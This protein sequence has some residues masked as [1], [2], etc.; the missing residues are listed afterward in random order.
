[1]QKIRAVLLDDELAGLKTLELLLKKFCPEVEVV[2]IFSDPSIAL[3]ELVK[4]KPDLLFLDIEMPRI[5]GFDFVLKAKKFEGSVVFVTAHSTYAVRAFKFSALDYLLKPVDPAELKRVVAKFKKLNAAK[6]DKGTVQQVI[7][8]ME[9]LS[10]PAIKKIAV[11]T[12]E[13]IEVLLL[14]DIEYLKADRNYTL[15]KRTGKKDLLVAKTL[16]EFEETLA[17]AQFM[18]LHSSYL[19]N[20]N[21]VA[22]FV[23]SDGGYAEMEDGAQISISRSKKEEFLER[24][25]SSM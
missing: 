14:E 5:T 17:S 9:F 19:V 7:K 4:I 16:K 24:L 20:M 1:M 8:N 18:R 10:N 15:I 2:A 11:P 6:P 12:N 22:R 25:R 21:K 3:T 13:S 23:R